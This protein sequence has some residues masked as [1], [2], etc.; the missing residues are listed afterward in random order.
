M[1]K[2]EICGKETKKNY[3]FCNDCYNKLST[4]ELIQCENCNTFHN[5]DIPCPKCGTYSILPENGFNQCIICGE[6]TKGHAFCKKCWKGKEDKELLEILNKKILNKNKKQI[7]END[8]LQGVSEEVADYR[9]KYP[10][11]IRCKDGHYVR[12]NNEKTID[13]RLYEKRVFH[14]Y[15]TR[16]KA[17][18]G[19][20]YY[21]DF[22]L[23]DADVFIEYFGVSENQEKNNKK[24]KLFMKDNEHHFEFIEYTKS[25]ILDEIIYDI[26]EKYDLNK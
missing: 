12:S 6:R 15:E 13:D 25:G 17:K 5:Y 18:D 10:A 21:P 24:R 8:D 11:T 2:C 9:K 20:Y 23:P 19:Q 3:S 14:E 22:Y 4:G 16:Y 26:I 7:I 1:S